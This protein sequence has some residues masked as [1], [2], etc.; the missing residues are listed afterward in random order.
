MTHGSVAKVSR[1][2]SDG[3]RDDQE[4]TLGSIGDVRGMD[5]KDA[6]R[7]RKAGVRTTEALLRQASSRTGRSEL[8]RDSG[9]S[10][11][12]IL[13]WAH[14]ADLM[15]VRGV[16]AEYAD[17]LVSVGVGTVDDLGS[18]EAT[19]L[20]GALVQAN[21]SARMVRRLPTE[22]MVGDWIAHAASL[23]STVRS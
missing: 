1:R 15:R 21:E 4:V 3:G 11:R 13:G 19:S 8:A 18:R 2:S 23:G 17:L 12:S 20:L 9:L 10:S 5:P 7:L 6:T 16:G 22:S 14:R